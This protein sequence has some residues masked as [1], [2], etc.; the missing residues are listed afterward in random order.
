MKL[1]VLSLCVFTTG[2]AFLG[3]GHP[4]TSLGSV[5][6]AGI[7]FDVTSEGSNVAGAMNNYAIKPQA[8][9]AGLVS[10]SCGVGASAA[11]A[12]T[13]GVYDD[14]DGDYDCNTLIPASTAGAMLW[15]VISKTDGATAAGAA[16]L[17]AP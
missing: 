9:N 12:T 4:D 3:C 13:V 16:A 6:I 8:G 15:I 11:A 14:D 10:V 7:T 2:A 17:P 5:A 1:S